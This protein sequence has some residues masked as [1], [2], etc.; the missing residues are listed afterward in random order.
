MAGVIQ[1]T[2]QALHLTSTPQAPPP[3]TPELVAELKAEYTKYDQ[4]HV[5]AFWDELSDT[6]KRVLFDQLNGFQP[7]RISVWGTHP[8]SLAVGN[9]GNLY[10]DGLLT[11]L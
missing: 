3:P 8:F 9:G 2:L 1:S 10:L 4:G 11:L 6:E 5:F 7:A